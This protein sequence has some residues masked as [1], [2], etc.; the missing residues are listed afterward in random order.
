MKL[1]ILAIGA[2]PDDVELGCGATI[3]KEV[4][5]GKKVGIIDLTRGELG[6]RGTAETRDEEALAAAEILN[7]MVRENMRF[8]DGFF[9]NDKAH[10]LA[11]IS[12]IRKY[13]PDIVICNAIDDRHIDH[14]KG[15]KLASDACFLSGLLKIETLN[16]KGEVQKPWRPK[17]V[18]H[19][20]QW[21]NIEPDFVVDVSD[22]IDLKMKSVLAYKT[23]FFSEDSKE[24]QTPISSKNFTDSVIYRARDLG[25]LISVEY[26]E[27]FTVERYVGVNSLFDL[28]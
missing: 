23:Q 16:E 12:K 11:L 14:G 21:K 13:Q 19:F 17:Q 24:P 28:I 9:A 10:Q 20:I 18:Y 27:G 25:R 15:S 6:T 1:D 7:V 22:F 26:A 5:N 4:A 8:A 2:H 3:A